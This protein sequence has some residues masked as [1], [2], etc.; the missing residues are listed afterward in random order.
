MAH[1]PGSK[2][3]NAIYKLFLEFH[4][5]PA[6]SFD[7][8]MASMNKKNGTYVKAINDAFKTVPSTNPTDYDF[9]E[10]GFGHTD[11]TG[12][13]DKCLYFYGYHRE[14]DMAF[15]FVQK[16]L[17]DAKPPVEIDTLY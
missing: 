8:W 10:C 14:L 7:S 15:V 12:R 17:T 5:L 6:G 13:Y 4:K 11:G 2:E 1:I 16:L 3:Y 9:F